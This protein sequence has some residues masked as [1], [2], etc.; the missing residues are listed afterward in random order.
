M[1]TRI[2]LPS[3]G[4]APVT[5][6]TWNFAN[7]IN[8]LTFAGV[9]AK[10]N[11]AMASKLEAT[12]TVSP[13]AKAMFRYVVGPLAAQNIAGTVKLQMRALESNA[14]ANATFAIAVKIIKPDGTDRAVLLAQTASDL[15]SSPY[16]FL[17][18]LT[19]RRVY[20][21]SEVQ[22][23]PLTAGDA[24]AGD[25]LVIEIG[26]RSATT[27]TRN[28]TLRY[29]DTTA[30]DMEDD[31]TSVNDYAPWVEFS[32]D[33]SFPIAKSGSVTVSGVGAISA[34]ASKGARGAATVIALGA[35]LALGM[36]ARAGPTTVSGIGAIEVYGEK[37]GLEEKSGSVTVSGIG[38]ISVYGS[39][40]SP[41]S[42][43]I[44]GIGA[45]EPHGAKGGQSGP[46]I[47]GVGKVD[48][49][50]Q[51]GGRG[52]VLLSGIGA[53]SAE[54]VK[55]V[56]GA[57]TVVGIEVIIVEG[58]TGRTGDVEMS[59]I[60]TGL[61][62]GEKDTKAKFVIGAKRAAGGIISRASRGAR[63]TN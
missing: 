32:R 33:I 31:T 5:P 1:A 47:A 25:Y 10:I 22:P 16:E 24:L 54:G 40:A 53:I 2:Y 12:G 50:G 38:G 60:L 15:A 63:R 49:Y 11:S 43:V 27:T 29:G 4:A 13:I 48:A 45:V 35:M 26:F 30:A 8:P 34:P 42:V 51:K 6:Q 44:S 41:G 37:G 9:L 18:A 62:F 59:G 52:A 20:N 57:V 14:L 17:T 19:N 28:I 3:S 61:L 39:R 46:S 23:I 7:Q 21:A 58:S 36:T 55:D 56:S